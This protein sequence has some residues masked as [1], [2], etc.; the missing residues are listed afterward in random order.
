MNSKSQ[1]TIKIDIATYKKLLELKKQRGSP[2]CWLV[3]KAV[4]NTYSKK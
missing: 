4:E 2:I 3:D 1:K